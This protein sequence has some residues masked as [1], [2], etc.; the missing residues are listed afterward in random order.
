MFLELIC[1]VSCEKK[2]N[3]MGSVKVID[4]KRG[5]IYKYSLNPTSS[6]I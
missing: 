4:K 2:Q 6:L 1:I 5:N 3:L